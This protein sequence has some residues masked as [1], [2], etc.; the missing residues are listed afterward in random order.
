VTRYQPGQIIQHDRQS[1]IW[2]TSFKLISQEGPAEWLTEQ[3]PPSDAVIREV[4]D[5]Y[6]GQA[7]TGSPT[8]YPRMPI[9]DK[10]WKDCDPSDPEDH[11]RRIGWTTCEEE[12][13]RE[14]RALWEAAGRR[15]TVRFVSHAEWA[16]AF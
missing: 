5:Y 8:D 7:R 14:I 3:L 11:P 2:G 10:N 9:W 15:S 6:V 13:I 1:C 4:I 16:A 12:M